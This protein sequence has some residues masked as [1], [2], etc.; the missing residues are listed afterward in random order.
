MS[1]TFYELCCTDIPADQALTISVVLRNKLICKV[2]VRLDCCLNVRC[3][4]ED[5]GIWRQVTKAY[6]DEFK[7]KIFEKC[8]DS[9]DPKKQRALCVTL[10]MIGKLELLDGSWPDCI[11]QFCALATSIEG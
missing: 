5:T 1:G 2:S 4:G 6:R 3:Q 7:Q 11:Q 10:G 8:C 9:S